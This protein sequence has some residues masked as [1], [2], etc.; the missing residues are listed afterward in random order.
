MAA[1][2]SAPVSISIPSASSSA[3]TGRRKLLHVVLFFNVLPPPFGAADRHPAPILLRF[4]AA[5][6]E[7]PMLLR[8]NALMRFSPE[9]ECRMAFRSTPTGSGL[10]FAAAPLTKQLLLLGLAVPD[11]TA[12]QL[13]LRWQLRVSTLSPPTEALDN[14]RQHTAAAP[15][16]WPLARLH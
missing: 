9:Q 6:S 16:S 12:K 13:W 4:G 1:F 11:P 5:D 2:L 7:P 10:D 8:L 15:A 14:L 3:L